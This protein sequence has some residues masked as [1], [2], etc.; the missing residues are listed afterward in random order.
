M[1][2]AEGYRVAT[3]DDVSAIMGL[4]RLFHAEAYYG[5]FSEARV[6]EAVGA[7]MGQEGVALV[8]ESEAGEVVGTL[9]LIAAQGWW[10][11]DWQLQDTWFFVHP[12]HR[13]AG[14]AKALL[15]GSRAVARTLGLPLMVGFLGR[16]VAG[17]ARLYQREFGEPIGMA[18]FVPLG[19]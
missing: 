3:P 12:E 15:R 18:F 6:L 5:A 10:T 11:E 16:R 13:R 17:K 19:G 9:G 14:H 8:A 4:L 1:N 2:G 7:C